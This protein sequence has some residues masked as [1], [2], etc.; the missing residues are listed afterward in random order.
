[1]AKPRE[2]LSTRG[3]RRV[4]TR[5]SSP[6]VVGERGSQPIDDPVTPS[7]PQTLPMVGLG[8]SAGS[9]PALQRFFETMPADSGMAF[10]VILHLSPEHESSLAEL[11]QR[12]TT[13]PVEQ[14][15]GTAKVDANRV[16]VIPPGK[17]LTSADGHLSLSDLPTERGKRVAVDVFFRTLADS[18][19]PQSTAIVL[20]GADGD[21]S[22]GIKRIKERGGLTIAQDPDEASHSSMPRSAI[23][24]GMVDWVLQVHEMPRRL[25]RYHSQAERLKL[26]R[27]D[28][29]QPARTAQSTS[30][31]N[32]IALRDVL[33]HLRTRTGR[34]FA[35]Y[36]RATIVRRIARRM[37]V[38]GVENM[39]EYLEFLR[40]HSGESG[41]L[42]QDLLI[43]VT[44]FFRD[45]DAFEALEKTIPGLFNGK[46][47]S[48]TLRVWVPAC[49]TGEEPYSIA[50]MLAE[51]ARRLDTPPQIQVFATDLDEEVIRVARDG[52]YPETI[53]ADVSDE[54]L[55][56]F[57]AK[58]HQGYRVRREIR[59]LVLFALHDLVMD[60][61]FSRL[62]LI[63]CRNLLIYLD[64]DAQKRAFETFHFSLRPR[65]M[66]FLGMSESAEDRSDLYSVVDKK[67]RIYAH[68]ATARIGLRVP[69]G[70]GTASLALKAREASNERPAM[71]AMLQP[72][73]AVPIVGSR[74]KGEDG[75][76]SWGELHFKLLERL[77][78]PSVIIDQNQ[79]IVHLSASAGRFM[80]VPGGQVTRSVLRA[81]HPMLR[82]EVRAALYRSQQTQ[83]EAQAVG[84]PFEADGRTYAVDVTVA[85]AGEIAPDF[86]FLTF[87]ARPASSLSGGHG[88]ETATPASPQPEL[89]REIDDLKTTLRGTIEQHE[90]STEELRAS[91]EELQA[92]NEELR[93]A[94]EELESSREE[95]QSINEE[96]TTVNHEL[97]NK[98]D[99]LGQTNSDLHNL[100]SSTSIATVFLDRHLHITRYTASAVG[101]FSLIPGDVGRPLR[102]L[103]SQLDYGH[104]AADA[105]QVM[106]KLV[107][108]D[109]EVQD[110]LGR[111]YLA[112]LL[113]YRTLDDR[114][115]GIVLNFVDITDRKEIERKLHATQ[116]RIRLIVD[117]ARDYAIFAIDFDR[118]VSSWNPAAE[119]MFGFA[120]AEIIGKPGD[121][122]FVPEDRDAGVPQREID[123]ALAVG[124]AENERWH[125]RADGVRFYGSGVVMPLRN[126][127]EVLGFVKIMR[128]LTERKRA[129]E[130]LRESEKL[131]RARNTELQ[132]FNDLAVDRELKMVE[133]KKEVNDL[134][135]RLGDGPSHNVDFDPDAPPKKP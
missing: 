27:E 78:P 46:Q 116:E 133:L 41:A 52:I 61:P 17:S 93:S 83:H 98:L 24:T 88:R 3:K 57:F 16:Y 63:S 82:L 23:S 7:D 115:A 4:A 107:P 108:I 112:R 31:Q 1:M 86:M 92:M 26:P 37:Q 111:W 94:S 90:A 69:S 81:L 34:D 74:Q 50:I 33:K 36:K 43:S 35:H 65:G 130:S 30:D 76:A 105:E 49:A 44:N 47:A 96:L 113:P 51:H 123:R 45:H 11:L 48:D 39:P 75:V 18:H 87:D 5:A 100:L 22:I 60:S 13:M 104:L 101:L 58:E 89:E 79:D 103:N 122:L 109:R 38:N 110:K 62:D 67:S 73:G 97:K 134:R 8:G 129:D 118:K 84:V 102:D 135:G 12:S 126:G 106:Q 71:P 91:N 64:R 120:E 15:N 80:H 77:G 128:D 127:E 66:L 29:P 19:G 53:Q 32:E 55:K 117:S 124:R 131:L 125:M 28:G 9:I 99:E 54:R 72:P 114:I 85:P 2:N 10:V 59:E 42:L 121:I 95:L 6:D 70:A 56:R 132:R 14:V 68:R 119:M 40:T 25:L 20:S 21:G